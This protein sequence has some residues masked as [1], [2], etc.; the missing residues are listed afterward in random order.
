[1]SVK[2]LAVD[3]EDDVRRLIQIKLKKA[4]FEVITAVNG[5]EAVEKCMAEKP[6]VVIMDWMMPK[7]D[8]PTA[9]A[10]IKAECQPAPIVLMLT[11]KG[12]ET[13]VIQGLVGGADDYIVKPFAPRELIARVNVALVKAGKQPV[14]G[15]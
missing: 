7:M 11:A 3:D 8:G 4:G 10:K 12:A 2:V 9:T 5:E 14:M 1:M 6:E 15:Q 13:D